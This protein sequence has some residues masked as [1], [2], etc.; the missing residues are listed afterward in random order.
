MQWKVDNSM[1]VDIDSRETVRY[2]GSS[3]LHGPTIIIIHNHDCKCDIT[4]S[5]VDFWAIPCRIFRLYLA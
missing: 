4:E 5:L 3:A 2:R 1:E